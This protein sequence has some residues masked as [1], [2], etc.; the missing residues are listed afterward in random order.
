[1][2]GRS[3][4]LITGVAVAGLVTAAPATAK[5][6]DKGHFHDVYTDV[7]DCEGTP[8]QEDGDVYGNFLFNQRG[9]KH[10]FPY[11]RESVRGTIAWTNLNTGGAFTLK[12]TAN[13]RDHTI[14]DNGDGTITITLFA[15]GGDRYYDQNG[16][17]VLKDT[18]HIRFAFEVDYNGTPGNPEDDQEVAD[19]FRVVRESTGT[20]R[21][22]GP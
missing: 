17:L 5:P 16:K 3:A 21:H 18:G 22:R 9:P 13:R 20:Q 6:L 11:F 2:R 4:L 12:F 7:F 19:S 10:P 1:M 15:S 8:V 14:V